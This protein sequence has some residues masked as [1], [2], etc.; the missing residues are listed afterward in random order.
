MKKKLTFAII[1]ILF[2]QVQVYSQSTIKIG[3][4]AAYLKGSSNLR[5]IDSPFLFLKDGQSAGLEITFVPKRGTARL[6]LAVDYITGTNDEKA[7]AAYSKEQDIP[8]KTFNF[9]KANP[10]GISVMVSPQFMLFKNAKRL[11]LMWL[12]FKAGALFNNQQNLQF[13]QGKP[14]PTNE[15]KGTEMSLVY[16]PTLVM[17]LIKTK[18]MF[19]NAKVGYSNFGGVS[20]GLG[21]VMQ[22]CRNVPCYRCRGTF[23]IEPTT[24]PDPPK[25][26]KGTKGGKGK[27]TQD[28]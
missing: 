25:G 11:P 16:N 26:T 18:N 14:Q 8:Y 21:I 13:F 23:C 12:D 6:K 20:V 3:V 17:N 4:N 1:A 28:F 7:I 22:D 5:N 15:I 9:T 2:V 19:L 24:T 10:S 27:Y